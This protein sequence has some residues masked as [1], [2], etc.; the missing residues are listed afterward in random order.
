LPA[1]SLQVVME[2]IT[3]GELFD[4]LLEHGVMEERRTAH[5]MHGVVSAIA[6]L[7]ERGVVHRDVKVM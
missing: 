1:F 6:Y 3:G 4:Y 7:H 5:L 2:L